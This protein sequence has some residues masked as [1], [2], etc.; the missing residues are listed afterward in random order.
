MEINE[1]HELIKVCFDGNKH[2][3]HVLSQEEIK[4]MTMIENRY[5]LTQLPVCGHCEKLGMWGR[6]MVG[7]CRECGTITKNPVNYATYLASGYDL[8]A[9]G[10]IAKE[11]FHKSDVENQKR[12]RKII[13]PQY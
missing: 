6:G 11:I 10:A 5:P 2:L 1:H 7:I 12:M 13:L 4:T 3:K 9:T 8:D